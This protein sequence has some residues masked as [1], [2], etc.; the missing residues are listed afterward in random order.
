MSNYVLTVVFEAK[1]YTR[2]VTSQLY[3]MDTRK[4]AE[5][6]LINLKNDMKGAYYVY[7]SIACIGEEN[8]QQDS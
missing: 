3:N 6:I 8:A 4:D 1:L 5:N 7:G 2:G